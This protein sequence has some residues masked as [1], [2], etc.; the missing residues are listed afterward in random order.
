MAERFRRLFHRRFVARAAPPLPPPVPDAD[1]ISDE[2]DED[3][4]DFIPEI[5]PVPNDRLIQRLMVLRDPTRRLGSISRTLLD[6][7]CEDLPCASTISGCE[8]KNCKCIVERCRSHAEE[9][10]F[11][12]PS[13]ARTP[14]HVAA[15]QCCCVHV[16]RE[17]TEAAV[18]GNAQSDM[19]STGATPLILFFKG[20]ARRH[21]PEG[22]ALEI[23]VML[24]GPYPL[25]VSAASDQEGFT[26]LHTA[27]SVPERMIPPSL[28][29]RL[30]TANELLSVSHTI[31]TA[32]TA[33]HLHCQRPNAS[34]Q[35]AQVLLTVANSQSVRSRRRITII[36]LPFN[37]GSG[38]NPC[39]YA[40]LQNNGDMVKYLLQALDEQQRGSIARTRTTFQN[41]TP[42]QIL[43]QHNHPS[44][45]AVEA[46]LEADS[47]VLSFHDHVHHSTPLHTLLRNKNVDESVLR[48]LL[49]ARPAS[50]KE[51]NGD[52]YLPLHTAVEAG[53]KFEI[54]RLLVEA[55]PEAVKAGTRARGT[56]LSLAC[57]ANKSAETV[58]LLLERYP[59][60]LLLPNKYGFLP[61]HCLCRAYQPQCSI[62]RV[63]LNAEPPLVAAQMTEAGDCAI[64]LASSGT[65]VSVSVLKALSEA[66]GDDIEAEV[67][68]GTVVATGKVENTGCKFLGVNEHIVALE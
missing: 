67:D 40:A 26:A 28:I 9:V 30:L 1:D 22:Q 19:D 35:V 34:V 7:I 25:R 63:L 32:E 36:T 23:V 15:L 3:D 59:E 64:H 68:Q 42:L 20:L 44:L 21:V 57:E 24:L 29:Q 38:F 43:C 10:H 65:N 17:I 8:A 27:C 45:P 37:D 49:R 2:G 6:L 54:V 31:S 56:A 61:L 58:Q 39:H 12:S 33:L 50:L 5:E 51:A 55:Y 47:S 53:V 66:L 11:Q 16:I 60:G 41:W 18:L 13:T 4:E 14:L 62:L 46:L 52:Q 48:A